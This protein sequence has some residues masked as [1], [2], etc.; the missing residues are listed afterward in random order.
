[1]LIL[2]VIGKILLIPVWI[3]TVLATAL[4]SLAVNV[5]GFARVIAGIVLTLLLIGTIVCY[6]DIT[7]ALFLGVLILLGYALLFAGVSVEVLCETVRDKVKHMIF[8]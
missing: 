2:K 6:Q 8:A 7:Q 1:M 4:V 5:L 3:I